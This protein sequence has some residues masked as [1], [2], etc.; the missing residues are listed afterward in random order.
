M[1]TSGFTRVCVCVGVSSVLKSSDGNWLALQSA[2][3]SYPGLINR[4]KS[5][6]SSTLEREPAALSTQESQGSTP[7]TEAEPNTSWTDT[8]QEIHQ[9]IA[10]STGSDWMPSQ[11]GSG[12]EAVRDSEG[13]WTSHEPL[14]ALLKKVSAEITQTSPSCSNSTVDLNLNVE[15]DEREVAA[16]Q[17]EEEEKSAPSSLPVRNIYILQYCSSLCCK[18]VLGELHSRLGRNWQLM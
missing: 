16:E 9:A 13:N 14:L 6:I 2:K 12:G 8:L 15:E 17:K 10:D 18:V 3:L 4:R 7:D 1:A 5:L 11:R